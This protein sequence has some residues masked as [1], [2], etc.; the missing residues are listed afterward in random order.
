MLVFSSFVKENLLAGSTCVSFLTFSLLFCGETELGK[1]AHAEEEDV[2]E[3]LGEGGEVTVVE[4]VADL[5]PVAEDGDGEWAGGELEFLAA[6]FGD[7]DAD[8]GGG[9]EAQQGLLEEEEVH[10]HWAWA[11]E[12]RVGGS[13]RGS[14]R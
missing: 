9:E 13:G 12:E 1:M 6:E 5:E 3:L 7:G 14:V 8:D 2:P 4:V 10:C 11:F